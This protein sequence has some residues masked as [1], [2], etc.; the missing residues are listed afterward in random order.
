MSKRKALIHRYDNESDILAVEK[1][2]CSE[3]YKA[4]RDTDFELVIV[5]PTA[6]AR[7]RVAVVAEAV[8]GQYH[9]PRAKA[10]PGR[11]DAYPVRV[12]VRNVRYT[13]SERVRYAMK[14][15]GQTWAAAW[16][17]CTVELDEDDL[18]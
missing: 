2:G 10:W 14:K 13:T 17:I 5:V 6:R 8:G 3:V 11:P 9:P 16:V 7:T 12:N 1:N 15:A 4:S 18:F